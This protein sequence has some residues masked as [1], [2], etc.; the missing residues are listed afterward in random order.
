VL[1]TIFTG[2]GLDNARIGVMS[3]ETGERRILVRAGAYARYCPSGHLVYARAGGLMAV[4]FDLRRLE[5]TGPPVSVLDGVS[6]NPTWFSAEFSSSSD[7]SLA[8][9]PGGARIADRTLAW[10]DRKGAAQSL[11]V[12]PSGYVQPRLSPDRRRLVIG[13]EG[14]GVWVYD[15]AQG[16][17]TRLAETGWVLPLPIWTPDGRHVTFRSGVGGSIN[18][19]WIPADGSGA[20]ERLTA[21]ED[22]QFAG[23]WSPDGRVLA[24][25]QDDP[26]TGG[27]IWVL[28]LEGDRKARPFLL[29]PSNEGG[30]MFSPDGRWLAYVSDESGRQEIYVRPF[31]GPGGKWP[32]STEG[33]TEPMWA[34]NG[35]ELF[36]RNGDKMMVAAVETK[37]TFA[38]AKPRVLFEGHYEASLIGFQPNYDVTL[39]GQR[40]IMIKGSEQAAT[41]VNVVLN[42]SD[43]LR[44]LVP[45]G[46]P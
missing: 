2:A 24:F 22:Q 13:K 10:V 21:G 38:A 5:V 43:E 15:L 44:R 46:K 26:A 45:A 18:L 6:M 12:A 37:P 28:S 42:W 32:V 20:A 16:T 17:L 8:Y 19:Y 9:V 39:D 41:Q 33:G 25:M 29:T 1:F 35:R 4:P 31:P 36:Y 34:R 23:S 7:G 30:A 14:A 40:F 11:S 27:D 3:L